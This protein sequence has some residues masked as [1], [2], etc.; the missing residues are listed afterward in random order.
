MNEEWEWHITV[1]NPLNI[2]DEQEKEFWN[3]L[4]RFLAYAER[5]FDE[6]HMTKRR[7]E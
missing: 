2:T 4:N 3:E 1:K 6:L 7:L 5:Y